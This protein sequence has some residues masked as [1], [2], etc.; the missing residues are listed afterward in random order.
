MSRIRE[1]AIPI[2]NG[3]LV[4]EASGGKKGGVCEFLD[5]QWYY[6]Y[7]RINNAHYRHMSRTTVL[8]RHTLSLYSL[9]EYQQSPALK[10]HFGQPC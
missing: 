3:V 1:S 10:L 4:H 5:G 2:A 7:V 6:P 8:V 9:F